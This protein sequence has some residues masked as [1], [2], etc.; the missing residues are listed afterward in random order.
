V[1]LANMSAVG[2]KLLQHNPFMDMNPRTYSIDSSN[3]WCILLRS[4]D[5]MRFIWEV[6]STA[7]LLNGRARTDN[8]NFPTT[9]KSCSPVASVWFTTSTQSR[10]T[11]ESSVFCQE[12]IE[13][14]FH[15]RSSN[16]RFMFDAQSGKIE[17][18]LGEH[19]VSCSKNNRGT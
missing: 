14:L 12:T 8:A 3:S 6:L 18:Q 4:L 10:S 15:C 9:L 1:N 13:S 7:A 5:L 19:W 2:W 11:S 16:P 17:G